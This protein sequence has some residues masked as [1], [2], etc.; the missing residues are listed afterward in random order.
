MF[1]NYVEIHFWSIFLLLYK[2]DAVNF[3]VECHVTRTAEATESLL[4]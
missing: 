4:Q 1:E 2:C 3:E